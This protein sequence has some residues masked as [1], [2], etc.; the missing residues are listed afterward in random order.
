VSYSHC[1]EHF[2]KSFHCGCYLCYFSAVCL[3]DEDNETLYIH[4]AGSVW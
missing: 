3:L 1:A 2:H 4:V